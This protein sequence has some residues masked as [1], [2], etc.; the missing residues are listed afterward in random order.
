MFI[1][2]PAGEVSSIHKSH[3]CFLCASSRS[4]FLVASSEKSDYSDRNRRRLWKQESMWLKHRSCSKFSRY[5]SERSFA[6]A[7]CFT[8]LTNMHKMLS[9]TTSHD[10]S[11]RLME[12]QICSNF[13]APS[14]CLDKNCKLTCICRWVYVA[15]KKSNGKRFTHATALSAGVSFQHCF[16]GK[17]NLIMNVVRKQRWKRWPQGSQVLLLWNICALARIMNKK[18]FSFH[19]LVFLSLAI[20]SINSKICFPWAKLAIFQWKLSAFAAGAEKWYFDEVFTLWTRSL[21]QMFMRH[22]CFQEIITFSFC[23]DEDDDDDVDVE[24]KCMLRAEKKSSKDSVMLAKEETMKAPSLESFAL[25]CKQSFEID[26][27]NARVNFILIT[28]ECFLK[29]AFTIVFQ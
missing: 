16:H 12:A 18:S 7:V 22:I 15:E 8:Y 5:S 23:N 17:K 21:T 6:F 20:S 4:T 2:A 10:S 11:N 26:S 24:G 29:K 13:F 1:I 3:N 28:N 25:I 19:K 14:S 9:T 27:I